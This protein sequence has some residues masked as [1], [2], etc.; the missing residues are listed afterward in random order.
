[1][2][3]KLLE[4]TELEIE[5]NEINPFLNPAAI[6]MKNQKSLPFLLKS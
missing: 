1:M 5:A 3:I 4:N 6:L 2:L